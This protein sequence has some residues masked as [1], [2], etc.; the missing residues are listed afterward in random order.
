MGRGKD[1]GNEV[2]NRFDCDLAEANPIKS[3]AMSSI[4]EV[5][6][7]TNHS[8]TDSNAV[9]S[10]TIRCMTVNLTEPNPITLVC[11][12]PCQVNECSILTTE[13]HAHGKE[14][15][16]RVIR[17]IMVLT[18]TLQKQILIVSGPVKSMSVAS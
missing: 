6:P 16:S 3:V 18:V 13:P 8:V 12:W 4:S 11:Q 5:F 14:V 9:K 10:W 2:Q 17:H 15:A 1:Q 7:G